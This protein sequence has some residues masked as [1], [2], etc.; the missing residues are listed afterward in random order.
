[1]VVALSTPI[2]KGQQTGG[3]IGENKVILLERAIYASIKEK[4]KERL[5]RDE[6]LTRLLS[7]QAEALRAVQRAAREVIWEED[8]AM[9]PGEMEVLIRLLMDDLFGLGPLEP[10]VKDESITE[11][12][13]NGGQGIYVE[14]EGKLRQLEL[15]LCE[16]EIYRIIDKIIGP[17]GLH[18]D[19]ASPYV[20]ARLPDGSRV[21]V[22]LPP[23]SLIGPVVTI[24]KFRA[25]PFSL[26]EL[27]SAGSLRKEEAM[28]LSQCVTDRKNILIS[29]GTGSGKTTLLN[30]L[31]A[32]IDPD[33][34]IITLED[35]AELRLLQPHVIP[36]ETRP[37]NLEG[38]G[39]VTMRDL[40]RNCL[41]M[42]PDRIIIGEVRGPEAMD[43]LQALNTGHQGSMTTVHANSPYDAISR[44]ETMALM[45][46]LGLTPKAVRE[47]ILRALEVLVHLERLP[48]GKRIVSEI[49][50]ITGNREI[51][52]VFNE[53]RGSRTSTPNHSQDVVRH[54]RFKLTGLYPT[55]RF[56]G[57]NALEKGEEIHGCRL[58]HNF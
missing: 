25:H 5:P 24:R 23:L 53:K 30:A 52:T 8:F 35:A 10:L 22:I 13:I 41:R 36:L 2:S 38:R 37:P 33:E 39:E 40:L 43:L 16:G 54:D 21:N 49:S 31:S 1:M 29:G 45:A 3:E 44:L 57:S 9:E 56:G 11:V 58:G 34:R 4:V 46:G 50:V 55:R 12:M 6:G 48:N 42:R 28:F 32:F 19:E 26:H 15:C 14:R 27:V 20:D 7:D 18:V 47:Q 51:V 17:L